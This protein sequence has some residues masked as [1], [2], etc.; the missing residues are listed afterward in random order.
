M[1][2]LPLFLLPVAIAALQSCSSIEA[3]SESSAKLTRGVPGGTF[4]Q[5][6]KITATVTA[7]DP[8]KRK[9]AL[10][11]PKGE[12][13]SVEA[14][15]EVTNF[16]QIRIGDQLRVT[17]NEELVVRMAKPGE[18]IEDRGAA[19]I[20]LAPAGDKPGVVTAETY[21]TSAT[22][23]AINLKK[24]KATL[25]FTD[26]STKKVTV[27]EDVDLSKHKVGDKVVIQ[28]T[29]TFAILLEKP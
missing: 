17:L 2:Y 5:T 13:L 25:Q 26:G 3:D 11:T 19:L 15:S 1:K 12:K 6:T 16:D 20:G 22:V 29:E 10:V 23:T 9:I 27:R 7:I 24:R 4:V 21:E 8:A 18:K 28:A 14:D